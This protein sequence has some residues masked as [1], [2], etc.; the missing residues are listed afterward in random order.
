MIEVEAKPLAG[1]DYRLDALVA[2][3]PKSQKKDLARQHMAL[4]DGVMLHVF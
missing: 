3:R 2:V 1:G 4:S